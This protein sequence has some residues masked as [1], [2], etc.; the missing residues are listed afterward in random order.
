[1]IQLIFIEET[2]ANFHQFNI[3]GGPDDREA[4]EIVIGLSRL[5]GVKINIIRYKNQISRRFSDDSVGSAGSEDTIAPPEMLVL[6]TDDDDILDYYFGVAGRRNTFSNILYS[7][8]ESFSPVTTATQYLN[9][10]SSNDLVVIGR[11][12][13][14]IQNALQFKNADTERRKVLGDVAESMLLCPCSASVLVVQGS[15]IITRL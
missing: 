15:R 10:L 1:M 13:T 6:D 2:V 7:E 12:N 14:R 4:L 11:G 3:I 5:D 9:Q 8:I